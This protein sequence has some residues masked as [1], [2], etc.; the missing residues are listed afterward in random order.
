MCVS[1]KSWVFSKSGHIYRS[2]RNLFKAKKVTFILFICIKSLKIPAALAVYSS[3]CTASK[4]SSLSILT[5]LWN[6]RKHQHN[7]IYP[8]F[9]VTNT[10]VAHTSNSISL[11]EYRRMQFCWIWVTETI[12]IIPLSKLFSGKQLLIPF[13]Q[14]RDI[15]LVIS[16]FLSLPH[17]SS[18]SSHT[19][20][21]SKFTQ[22]L[23]LF[24][25]LS[26]NKAVSNET[27]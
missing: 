11:V 16:L 12:Y 20:S 26:N 6:L 19:H 25:L 5:D 27:S 9:D 21:I 1:A 10:K 17:S 4:S 14:T 2:T 23:S 24:F 18:Y 13:L 22:K 7:E 15:S 3:L 8:K